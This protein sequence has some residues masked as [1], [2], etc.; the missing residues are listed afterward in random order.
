MGVYFGL[1]VF[2]LLA[3]TLLPGGSEIGL[4]AL[5]TSDEHSVLLLIM[6]AT[7]GNVLG[8]VVNWCLGRYFNHFQDRP[9]YP[10]K[11]DQMHRAESWYHKYGRWSLLASWV[12]II[13]DPLTL[14]SGILR[15]P[16]FS[17]LLL[18]TMAKLARYLVV[19]VLV[20]QII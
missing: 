7:V 4:A 8:S 3:A 2:S 9:W 19:T 6:F 20:L 10:I 13:G 5:L 11:P 18:V 14:I 15:E 12:P 16:L 17:F 1:F